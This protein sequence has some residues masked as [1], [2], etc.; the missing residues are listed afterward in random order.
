MPNSSSSSSSFDEENHSDRLCSTVA[1][2]AGKN[3]NLVDFAR[4]YMQEEILNL[5]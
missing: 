1:K 4:C 2:M 3:P 5:E